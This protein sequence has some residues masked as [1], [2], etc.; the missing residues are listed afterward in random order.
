MGGFQVGS[1]LSCADAPGEARHAPLAAVRTYHTVFPTVENPISEGGV[2][3]GGHQA[4]ASIWGNCQVAS[5]NFVCGVDQP[6]TFGDPTAILKG[7]WPPTHQRAWGKVRLPNGQPTASAEL[8]IR[9]LM[10]IGP[11][12]ITGYEIYASC[13]NALPYAYIAGWGGGSGIYHNFASDTSFYLQDGDVIEGRS[14][15]S[16]GIVT[17]ELWHNG[18]MI[19]TMTD[20]GSALYTESDNQPHGPWLTGG[21]GVGFF[22]LGGTGVPFTH[23]G[24]SEFSAEA[25]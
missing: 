13:D 20:D 22:T 23:F 9:L 16:G 5:V 17:V 4:D 15:I 12:S 6:A 1:G 7:Y 18:T 3:L 25:Y 2:W 10:T 19:L 24:F 21:I 14:S 8:E 11:G